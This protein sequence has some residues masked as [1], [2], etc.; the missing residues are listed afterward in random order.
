MPDPLGTDFNL[1]PLTGALLSGR[2]LLTEDLGR[3]LRTRHGALFYDPDY[4]SYLPEYLG[5]GF[6]DG[7]AEAAAICM[8]DLEEDDRVLSAS[9]NVLST[10]LRTI[11]LRA[12]L[13]TVSGPISLIVEAGDAVNVLGYEGVAPFGVG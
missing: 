12:D 1:R 10:D 5:E 2:A 6:Q 13:E 7:G 4:G 11:Q 8:L 9:V 3:R